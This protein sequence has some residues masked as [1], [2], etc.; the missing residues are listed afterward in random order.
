MSVLQ[1]RSKQERKS[2]CR[3]VFTLIAKAHATGGGVR[4]IFDY[5]PKYSS[6]LHYTPASIHYY[7]QNWTQTRQYHQKEVHKKQKASVNLWLYLLWRQMQYGVEVEQYLTACQSTPATFTI[8]TSIHYYHQNRI[9]FM[10]V[11]QKRSQQE[12]RTAPAGIEVP[13]SW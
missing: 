11:L 6:Y 13:N 8:P 5:M 12:T 1:E 3:L 7:H 4:T 9:H 2:Y 10:S